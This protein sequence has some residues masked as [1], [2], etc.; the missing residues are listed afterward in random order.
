MQL[1]GGPKG[2]IAG[3]IELLQPLAQQCT[4]RDEPSE[5]DPASYEHYVELLRQGS[6]GAMRSSAA[7]RVLQRE[8][9]QAVLQAKAALG[10]A[11][12][13]LDNPERLYTTPVWADGDFPN[14][15]G[16]SAGADDPADAL[17]GAAG[18]LPGGM[19]GGKKGG[20]KG[21]GGGGMAGN[22]AP[23]EEERPIRRGVFAEIEQNR[24]QW[25]HKYEEL[26]KHLAD[27]SKKAKEPDKEP[28]SGIGPDDLE[29]DVPIG[30]PNAEEPKLD[31]AGGGVAA[32][33]EESGAHHGVAENPAAKKGSAS[34]TEK[35]DVQDLEKELGKDVQPEPPKPGDENKDEATLQREASKMPEVPQYDE[36]GA[37]NALDGYPPI[38]PNVRSEEGATPAKSFMGSPDMVPAVDA[39]AAAA[40]SALATAVASASAISRGS[41][42]GEGGTKAGRWRRQRSCYQDGVAFL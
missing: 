34:D 10:V 3:G 29:K 40:A 23:E 21:A 31:P 27:V 16:G 25:D 14:E 17:A 33:S 6:A 35:E 41:R 32:K 28:A 18:G 30:P 42:Y 24:R 15:E 2:G 13:I 8:A 12:R 5:V 26:M 1:S 39:I 11:Y 7:A 37:S 22:L 20:K 9:H 4:I 19:A 36:G 38:M